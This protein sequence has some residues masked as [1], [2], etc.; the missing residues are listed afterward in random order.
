MRV[1]A[2]A[3]S[4]KGGSTGCRTRGPSF[5]QKSDQRIE[6]P[7]ACDAQISQRDDLRERCP[8]AMESETDLEDRHLRESGEAATSCQSSADSGTSESTVWPMTKAQAAA[9][10][11]GAVLARVRATAEA[12]GEAG[13][14]RQETP[15]GWR[16]PPPTQGVGVRRL[17]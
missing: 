17:H 7:F 13:R 5:T 1:S 6:V 10:L 14:G 2:A 9:P 4:A 16:P 8:G 11:A 15:L 12:D 3:T